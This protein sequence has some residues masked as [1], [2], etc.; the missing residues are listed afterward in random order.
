MM[1]GCALRI[2]R[3]TLVPIRYVRGVKQ[4]LAAAIFTTSP[5]RIEA[6]LQRVRAGI[7]KINCS[8]ANAAV[9]L[10]FGGWK[11]SGIGPA[12]HGPSNR[13]F[14]TRMQAIYFA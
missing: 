12:E 10:P 6:F 13:E 8:T 11:T 5:K 1:I 14:F 4:G 9:D 3:V 7:I 2:P